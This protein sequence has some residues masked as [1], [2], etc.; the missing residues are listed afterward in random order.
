MF[1]ECT[2]WTRV[3]DDQLKRRSPLSPPP[4]SSQHSSLTE[5]GEGSEWLLSE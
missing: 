4:S 2:D 5:E 1:S 3:Q